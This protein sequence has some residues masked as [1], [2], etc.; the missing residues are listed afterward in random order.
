MVQNRVADPVTWVLAGSGSNL[1]EKTGSDLR[2]KAGSRTGPR[3]KPRY[4]PDPRENTRFR[5]LP[6]FY[7]IKF[8]FY[9]L[10]STKKSI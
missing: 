10:L 5:I 3:K 6:N 9:F 8:T 4:G 2:R 1:P 7:L